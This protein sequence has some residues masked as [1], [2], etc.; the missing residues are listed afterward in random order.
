M[1]GVESSMKIVA[2][3]QLGA[4]GLGKYARGVDMCAKIKGGRRTDPCQK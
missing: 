4:Q 2:L 3:G 1:K